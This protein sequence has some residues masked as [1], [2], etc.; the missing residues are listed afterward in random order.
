M[1][2]AECKL[3]RLLRRKQFIE[4]LVGVDIDSTLLQLSE[5][6]VQPLITDF[7]V[8]RPNPFVMRLMQGKC[9]QEYVVHCLV[10]KL[11]VFW[12]THT[13]YCRLH[14]QS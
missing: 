14:S 1:G 8:L 7:L 13:P 12:T 4:E 6:I 9:Y 2:C 5:N 11:N 10:I 3:L